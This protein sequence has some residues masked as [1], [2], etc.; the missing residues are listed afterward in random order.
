MTDHGPVVPQEL[1]YAAYTEV[2]AR[3][4][5][6]AAKVRYD[7]PVIPA[8]AGRKTHEDSKASHATA[9]AVLLATKPDWVSVSAV[10]ILRDG[11]YDAAGALMPVNL[12]ATQKTNLKLADVPI[13]LVWG[14][15]AVPAS[16]SAKPTPIELVLPAF[17]ARV[18]PRPQPAPSGRRARIGCR[19]MS[20]TPRFP[21]ARSRPE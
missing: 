14:S 3:A 19:G 21:A 4:G 16:V 12:N 8:L 20:A 10:N 1:L 9:A 6:T 18:R 2:K 17:P 11:K 15:G 5:A 7:T 13:R